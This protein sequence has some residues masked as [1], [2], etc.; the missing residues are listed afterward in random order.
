[1]AMGGAVLASDL[2]V[3]VGNEMN[4]NGGMLAR[5]PGSDASDSDPMFCITPSNT[6]YPGRVI[7]TLDTTAR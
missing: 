4:P 6:I 3:L 5:V 1:M 7:Y 2:T